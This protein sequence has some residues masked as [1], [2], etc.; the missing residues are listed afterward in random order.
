[1]Q[2][3]FWDQLRLWPEQTITSVGRSDDS[4]FCHERPWIPK[5]RSSR[6]MK[7]ANAFIGSP[8]ERIEDLRFVRGRGKF[9]DDLNF[10]GQWHGAVVRTAVPHGRIRNIDTSVALQMPGVQAV[11]TA[12]DIDSPI[13][14]VPFRRPNPVFAAYAQPVIADGFVRYVGEPIAFIL[15]ETSQVAEDAIAAVAADIE[16][17]PVVVDRKASAKG[18]VLLFK[19]TASNTA[20]VYTTQSGDV[21]AAFARAAY[22]RREQFR[23][24]RVSAMPMETRGLLAEWND[25][26]GSLKMYGAA[27]LPFFNR[28][29]LAAMMNLPEALV[30]YIELDVGGGFGARGEFYPEDFLV[31]FAARKFKRAVKWTEDRRE[32]FMAIGHS[33]ETECEIELAF[34]EKGTILALRGDVFVDIGAYVRPNG[35]TPVR[36]LAQFL[37]GPYVVPNIELRCHALVTNKT[38]SGTFRGPGRYEGCFF[39]ERMMDIAADELTLDRLEIRQ[40]NLIPASA[41]PYPLA[42]VRPLDGFNDTA[43]DSG[44]YLSAFALCVEESHWQEKSKLIGRLVDGRYHGLGVACFVEGGASGPRE[45]ARIEVEQGGSVALYVGSSAIG[46][47]VETIMAQ[48]AADA[49]EIPIDRIS[50]LHGSTTYLA[51]GFGSYGS[52]G[53]VMGGSAVLAAADALLQKFR[54]A[55]AERFGV[56]VEDVAIRDGVARSPSGRLLTFADLT[57]EPLTADGVFSNSKLTVTY[58]TAIAHVAVDVRTGKVSLLDYVVVDDVGRIINPLTL[59]GQVVGA[60]V[61]GMGSVFT[62]EIAYDEKGQILVG[63]LADYMLPVATDYPNVRAISLEQYPSPNNPL[64]A[65]GAGEGGVIPVAGAIANAVSSALKSFGIQTNEL[66]LSPSRIWELVARSR[67]CQTTN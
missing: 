54:A 55:A 7:R 58:G 41:M 67:S 52:R 24:Q 27:K 66:P 57:D 51:E 50:V 15:A 5:Q 22:R 18:D 30:D 20:N 35:M 37:T 21:V 26:A 6:R 60:A 39:F 42:P 25:A 2:S 14:K 32:H 11:I 16:H 53:T 47:G 31:A 44:D 48:I 38:P 56:A 61:Q 34:D 62:E 8:I 23:V 10:D 40:R 29:A 59:H 13:P 17:L 63:S 49:L 4:K 28:R 19:E 64:G 65:K 45:T 9:V 3:I 46:Q 43:C 36:N 1:M 12:K 33:R